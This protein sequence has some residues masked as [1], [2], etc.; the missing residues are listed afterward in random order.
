MLTY[1]AEDSARRMLVSSASRGANRIVRG[2]KT[3]TDTVHFVH[4]IVQS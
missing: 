2:L 3:A 1:L 4:H